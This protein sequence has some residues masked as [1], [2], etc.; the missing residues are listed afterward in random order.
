MKDPPSK[1]IFE[2]TKCIPHKDGRIA[3]EKIAET[4]VKSLCFSKEKYNPI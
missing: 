3:K 2:I 4:G 1:N